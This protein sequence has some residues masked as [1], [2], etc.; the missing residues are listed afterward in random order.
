VANTCHGC[1]HPRDEAWITSAEHH[2][3]LLGRYEADL[4]ICAACEQKD[5][6]QAAWHQDDGESAGGHWTVREVI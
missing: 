2:A 6:A 5:R 3:E 4:I 1:G